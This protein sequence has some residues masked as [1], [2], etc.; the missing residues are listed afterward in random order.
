VRY[1]ISEFTTKKEWGSVPHS[2]SEG[3]KLKQFA[4]ESI[5]KEVLLA[6][7]ERGKGDGASAISGSKLRGLIANVARERNLEFP[8]LEFARQKFAKFLSHFE[9]SGCIV[10]RV[11]EGQDVLVA[12]SD[13]PERLVVVP[14]SAEQ[15]TGLRHDLFSAF[16]TV[17][18]QRAFYRKD[19]DRFVWFP[20][21]TMPSPEHVAVPEVT[22]E[23]LAQ[24]CA[25]FANTISSVE[26]KAIFEDALAQPR[27]LT[28][29][30]AAVRELRLQS[31]WHSF[32]V[33][34]LLERIGN[35][36]DA[37]GIA[38]QS[39]WITNS[40]DGKQKASP[41]AGTNLASSKERRSQ[42]LQMIQALSDND[43][44]RV[45][46]PMDIVAKLLSG[47]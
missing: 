5:W 45:M 35:W 34:Q 26:Q 13:E 10:I 2:F 16:S 4:S 18:T 47:R 43:L 24:D 25:A 32:R 8:P 28:A 12:P 30:T 29:F 20:K 11:R 1:G 14:G 31:H 19:D 36:A 44:S 38:F 27:S 22:F 46:V 23:G 33:K 3:K 7:L 39:S 15:A 21:E 41:E 9:D 6:A 42:W 37:K 17:S 40:V